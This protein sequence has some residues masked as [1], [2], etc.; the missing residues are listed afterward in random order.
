MVLRFDGLYLA[1]CGQIYQRFSRLIHHGQAFKSTVS[2]YAGCGEG[3]LW[4]TMVKR[5]VGGV[6]EHQL[7]WQ[8]FTLRVVSTHTRLKFSKHNVSRQPSPHP[9]NPEYSRDGGG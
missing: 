7:H 9:H 8:I 5:W 2:D 1:T 3:F 6:S 4:D